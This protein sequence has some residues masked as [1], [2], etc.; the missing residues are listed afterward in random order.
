MYG[1]TLEQAPPYKIPLLYYII[2]IGYLLVLGVSMSVYGF[3]V[4]SRFETEAIAMTHLMTLGFFTHVMFGTLFQMVPVIIGEAYAKVQFYAK[5]LLVLLNLSIGGFIFSL[6]F[7]Q[8]LIGALSMVL[9]FVSILFFS[10]YSIKTVA[11]TKDKNPFVKTIL[12]ALFFLAFGA[13]FG[14]L[15]FLQHSG[16]FIAA[17]LGNLHV[18]VIFFGWIFLLYSGVSYK[19]LSMF[20]V[21]REYPLV[22]KNYLYLSVIALLSLLVSA[23]CL[24]FDI[25]IFLGNLTLGMVTFLFGVVTIIILKNRK[26]ARSDIAVNFFYFANTN[27][28]LGSVLWIV[29]LLFDL[30]MDIYVGIFFGLGFVYG[31]INAMLY[32]IVPFLTWFHLSS[33]FVHEAEMVEVI[34]I[35]RM[36]IQFYLYMGSYLL[37][38]FSSHWSVFMAAALLLF[39]ISTLL[40][41]WNVIS[42]YYYYQ[43]MIKKVLVYG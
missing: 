1:L 6:F 38:L 28:V 27:L 23:S 22:I 43:K 32:K 8:A 11:R 7:S 15:S 37:F 30:D 3:H 9:L 42:G 13:V 26:R 20:Y 25:A 41:G 33:N 5:I 36:K 19:I 39:L 17:W 18:K 35:K 12:S 4:K 14:T 34:K 21:A 2:S 16:F 40:L 31:I 24:E 10:I 29:A